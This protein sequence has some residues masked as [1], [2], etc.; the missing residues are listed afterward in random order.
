M[1]ETADNALQYYAQLQANRTKWETIWEEVLTYVS[2]QKVSFSDTPDT[3]IESNTAIYDSTAI[4]DLQILSAGLQSYLVTP[5]QPWFSLRFANEKM[6][7]DVQAMKWLEEVGKHIFSVIQN[8][9]LY[10]TLSEF[11]Y[12]GAMLGTSCLFLEEDINKKSI[13]FTPIHLREIYVDENR[14]G[15]VDNIFRSF[16]LTARNAV[17]IFGKELDESIRTEAE[18]NPYKYHNFLHYITP[19]ENGKGFSSVY[20]DPKRR[21]VLHEGKYVSCPYIVWRWS[22]TTDVYGN[23]PTIDA[24]SDIKKINVMEQT[25]LKAAQ[26]AV[27]PPLNV[28][29]ELKGLV[30]IQPRAQHYYTSPDRQVFPLNLA[31]NYPIG[32][33]KHTKIEQRIHETFRTDIFLLLSRAEK[34]MTAQEVIERQGEKAAILGGILGRVNTEVLQ[35]IIDRTF[36]IEMQAGRIAP[37]PTTLK[38]KNERIDIVYNSPIAQAQ[39]KY[40]ESNGLV[41]SL[42]AIQMVA[43]I[44]PETMEN[45]D[46]DLIARKITQAYGIPTDVIL[47]EAEV[48]KIRKQ[49]QTAEAQMMGQ[50]QAQQNAMVQ[51]DIIN[52]T[53]R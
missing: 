9:N 4:Y 53:K 27:E 22:K 3:K 30:K 29:N 36:D 43:Q 47:A 40:F 39:K 28:P 48:D 37:I 33:D 8:S 7:G 6:E 51:A 38:R 41:Q 19:Q 23:S 2:P 18:K 32:E 12:Q 31:G 50:A 44:R 49:R 24:L 25:L 17:K 11:F 42:Q 14:Y 20:I 46:F 10:N 16:W 45:F 15:Q 34:T 21:T 13:N 35:P 1:K 52:K 5:T 26:L